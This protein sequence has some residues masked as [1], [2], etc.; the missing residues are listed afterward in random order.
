MTTKPEK[1]DELDVRFFEEIPFLIEVL[2]SSFNKLREAILFSFKELENEARIFL[3][4]NPKWKIEDPK[5]YFTPFY[6]S[7]EKPKNIPSLAS[8]FTYIKSIQMGDKVADKYFEIACGFWYDKNYEI[9]SPYLYLGIYRYEIEPE[10][11][12]FPI[13]FYKSLKTN[14]FKKM[15]KHPSEGYNEE[16]VEMCV[17]KITG[18]QLVNAFTT[19]SIQVLQP[20][21]KE[22]EK[23]YGK[24]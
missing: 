11:E 23:V 24:K 18:E 21:L 5:D 4:N 3:K 19:F 12:L 16:T 15:I 1:I 2:T 14:K 10:T 7:W 8:K 9:D 20:F 13:Q 22:F 17:L 6:L